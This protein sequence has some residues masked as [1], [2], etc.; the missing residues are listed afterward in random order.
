MKCRNTMCDCL[1]YCNI[2]LYGSDVVKDCKLRKKFNRIM[3]D[4]YRTGRESEHFYLLQ[5][6]HFLFKDRIRED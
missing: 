2:D 3:S 4:W 1:E 6:F 5:D